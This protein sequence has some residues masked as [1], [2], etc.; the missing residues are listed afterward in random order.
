MGIQ[1]SVPV[2]FTPKGLT[3]AYDA[4]DVF[5]G[6]CRKISNLVFDQSNPELLIARP[7][8]GDGFTNFTGFTTPGYVS[9]QITVGRYVYGMIATGLTAGK[10]QPFC[11]DLVNGSNIAISGVTAGNAENRP[12]SPATSGPWTPPTMAVVGVKVIITHP[13]Y[14]G[15]VGQFFGVIDIT[16][17][18]A[19]AYS[20]VN[21]ATNPLPRV[22][23]AVANFN[24]RAYFVCGNQLWYSDVLVPLT[25][26]N[27][28]QSLTLGDSNPITAVAGL[29]IQTTSAGV[30]QA[31]LVFKS[32]QI[33]QVI[34]DAA[35]TNS[36]ALNYL[37]LNI[38]T[39]APRS[40]VSSPL[41]T[42]FAGPDSAYL[43]T[44]NGIVLT[45]TNSLGQ[46]IPPDIRQMF[47]FVTEPTR[48][49]AAFAANI[50]RI[51]IPTIIDGAPATYDYWFDTRK[52]RWNGPH[53]F[54]Y[55]CAS[56]AGTYFVL[57]GVGKLFRSDV[58]PTSL[59]SY[60]DNGATYL[61]D[62][63]TSDFPKDGGMMM[64]QVVE[65]TMEFSAVGARTIYN[66]TAYGEDGN[67]IGNVAVVT[68]QVGGI[69]GGNLWL[70]GTLWR[71]AV[72]KPKTYRLP[73]EGPLV[74]NKL[75]IEVNCI[76]TASVIMGTFF[77][78]YQKTGYL[79]Q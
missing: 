20:T 63:V 18:L 69:W 24:N 35:I 23:T 42:F 66:V 47:I 41:G 21:T 12:T 40:V 13:G 30:V 65:C 38:G 1:Q 79:L 5:N 11:Y 56:S 27:A 73:W 2:R 17:P 4:T 16:N 37:S 52:M 78:R 39:V 77:A 31:L 3:D 72:S 48:V 7:G 32:T 53:T 6:A 14:S 44:Q 29:P 57:S 68:N 28:G 19:P 54:T 60:S 45:V 10:D 62:L 61:A 33:W 46:N 43:V 59:T 67:Q 25:M 15:A 8:V 36:L 55:E 50:Y 76:A 71:S 74:F 58:A 75:S 49:A 9:V 34:G 26:T 64:K 22:P 70:D 51:C